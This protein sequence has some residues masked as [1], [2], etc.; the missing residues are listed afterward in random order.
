MPKKLRKGKK[1]KTTGKALKKATTNGIIAETSYFRV[2]ASGRK[3]K[4]IK[5]RTDRLT[6][7]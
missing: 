6:R 4:K 1:A 2:T 5:T 7:I 3:G